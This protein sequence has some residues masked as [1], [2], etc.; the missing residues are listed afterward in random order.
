MPVSPSSHDID[1][2]AGLCILHWSS[3][4]AHQLEVEW[5]DFRRLIDEQAL[6]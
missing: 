5:N 3:P 1:T 6:F 2:A 4:I